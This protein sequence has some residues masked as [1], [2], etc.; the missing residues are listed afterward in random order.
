MTDVQLPTAEILESQQKVWQSDLQPAGCPNCS[1]AFL[2]EPARI[3]L[4]CPAC[5]VGRLESQPARLRLEPPEL[6]IPFGKTSPNLAGLYQR[7]VSGVWLRP[8]DFNPQSLLRRATPLYWP[9]WLVDSQVTG[10]WQA[11]VGYDYQ[12][13]SSQDSY[14][15][16]QWLSNKVVETRIRWEPRLGQLERHFDNIATPALSDNDRLSRLLGP[17]RPDAA[18]PYLSDQLSGAIVRVPD[19]PP[20]SAWPL[21]QSQLNR[22]AG[23]LCQQAAGGQHIR[24]FQLQA[25]YQELNWTQLLQPLYVSY[26]TDDE[27]QPQFVYINPQTGAIGGLR[28]ASQRKGWRWAGI[29]LGLALIALIIGV[30]AFAFSPVL[31]PLSLLGFLACAAAL[32][33]GIFAIVPA[34]WPWQ[35]NRQQRAPKVVST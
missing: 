28:L 12:V 30:V 8:D 15:S 10:S 27:G 1:Q 13:E 4:A 20:E 16:G 34:V 17:Y 26:Y 18:Q 5:G 22:K 24:N 35:W 6:V 3:G 19:L 2:V 7:F 21:A 31:P 14:A 11:E 9:L 33:L 32:A 29:S 23:D 25:E